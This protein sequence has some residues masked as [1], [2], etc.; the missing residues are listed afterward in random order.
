MPEGR[1]LIRGNWRCIV[2][3]QQRSSGV[4]YERRE[5]EERT[6]RT[7]IQISY[8]VLNG[9]LFSLSLLSKLRA[10]GRQP[11]GTACAWRRVVLICRL[12]RKL[13][14]CNVVACDDGINR[15]WRSFFCCRTMSS[16]HPLS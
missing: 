7:L 6:S 4:C 1:L 12:I 2:W 15:V 5:V 8:A 3:T 11:L 10:A 16:L 14:R 9:F 13:R